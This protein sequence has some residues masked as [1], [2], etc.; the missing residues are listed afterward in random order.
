MAKWVTTLGVSILGKR[1]SLKTLDICGNLS[2]YICTCIQ[3]TQTSSVISMKSVLHIFND[4][5][6]E[7]QDHHE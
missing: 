2:T 3:S 6:M 7:K 1:F 4:Y 5:P